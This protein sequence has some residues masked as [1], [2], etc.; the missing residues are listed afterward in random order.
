MHFKIMT[1]SC[2]SETPP[3]LSEIVPFIH[4]PHRWSRKISW[5]AVPFFFFFSLHLR[6]Y[7]LFYSLWKKWKPNSLERMTVAL[8]RQPKWSI[9]I[10][11]GLVNKF[12]KLSGN[13]PIFLMCSWMINHGLVFVSYVIVWNGLNQRW[14]FGK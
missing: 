10:Y 9:S 2:I 8:S 4:S 7:F 14:C 3:K 6:K 1:K 12:R 5:L 11:M 13:W